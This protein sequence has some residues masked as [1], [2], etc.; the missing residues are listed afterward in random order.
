LKFY[1]T[2]VNRGAYRDLLGER[3]LRGLLGGMG[4]SALGDGMSA[5]TVAWLAVQ[6]APRSHLGVFVGMAVAAYSLPGALGAVALGG[7][8]RGWPARRLLLA[9]CSL[10]AGMLAAI[11]VLSLLGALSPALYLGLLGA[12]SVMAAWGTSAEY[13]LLSV[14]GGP[15]QRLAANSLASAQTSSALIIGPPLAGLLLTHVAAGWLIA[16]DACSFALLG[17]QALRTQVQ[18]SSSGGAETRTARASGF[19]AL[20][21]HGLWGLIAITWWFF[22]LYGPVETALPVYVAHDLHGRAGLLGA[23]WSAFGIGALAATLITG[24]TRSRPNR[25]VILLVVAGWGVCLLPFAFA[26]APTTLLF[27]AI[28]G[29]IYGPFIPLTYSVL[30]SAVP[31]HDLPSLLAARSAITTVAAPLGTLAGGPL[32]GRLGAAGTITAS[33]VATLALAGGASILWREPDT[34]AAAVRRSRQRPRGQHAP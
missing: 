12:S 15:A 16:I 4:A 10:R 11:G 25:R 32:I 5:V 8:V 7:I 27:F 19:A 1:G 3:D 29:V 18:Q 28:G 9:D 33:G 20:R 14:L 31:A 2:G 23:Y 17:A 21:R 30:Q 22:F 34:L 26:G 13:T 6:L 24:L